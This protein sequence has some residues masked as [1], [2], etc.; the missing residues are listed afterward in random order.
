MG[1]FQLAIQIIYKSVKIRVLRKAYHTNKI[2]TERYWKLTS[3]DFVSRFAKTW[4]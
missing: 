3:S 2:S 1:N 4:K